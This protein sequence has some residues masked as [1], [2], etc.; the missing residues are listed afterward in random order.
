MPHITHAQRLTHHRR[1]QGT[2]DVVVCSLRTDIAH[3]SRHIAFT[4]TFRPDTATR[5]ML[6]CRVLVARSHSHGHIARLSRSAVLSV[7]PPA[8]QPSAPPPRDPP[9]QCGGTGGTRLRG[10]PPARDR[11]Q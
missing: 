7:S 9:R 5:A 3:T 8:P 6:T 2:P 11:L 1:P 4:P 10:P